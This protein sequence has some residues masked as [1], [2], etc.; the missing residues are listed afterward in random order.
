MIGEIKALAKKMKQGFGIQ[1]M[2]NSTIQDID[3]SQTKGADSKWQH[4]S[5]SLFNPV[6]VLVSTPTRQS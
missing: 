4:N 1:I 6:A 3:F 2:R 5:H